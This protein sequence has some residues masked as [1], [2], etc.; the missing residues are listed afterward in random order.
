MIVYRMVC[1]LPNLLLIQVP[2]ALPA[3]YN[4][5]VILMK[6]QRIVGQKETHIHLLVLGA[7]LNR[8][9]PKQPVPC[10]PLAGCVPNFCNH[11]DI[12]SNR[13]WR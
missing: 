11:L 5:R 12:A 7:A 8:A 10:L 3:W 13:H 4:L 1:Y 2:L 6:N 9:K